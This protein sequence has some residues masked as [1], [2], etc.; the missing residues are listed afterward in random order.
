M[1][2][3]TKLP[4]V[5]DRELRLRARQGLTYWGRCAVAALA[6][7]VTMEEIEATS[8]SVT[9][10]QAGAA[11]F[12][13]VSWLAFLVACVSTLVTADCLSRERRE[14]TLGL[15]LL[16]DLKGLDV[17]LGK[18]CVAG[19]SAAYALVGFLPAV[20]LVVLMGGV[21]LGEIGRTALALLNAAFVALAA[22]MWVSGRSQ[23]RSGAARGSLLL[24]AALCIA[25]GVAALLGLSVYRH[26][27]G[28]AGSLVLVSP[29]APFFLA[30]DANY[31]GA[32]W[33]YWISLA[34]NAVVGW[35]LLVW[36]GL[37]LRFNWKT[38][39][40][41]PPP[42]PIVWE[43]AYEAEA[44][45]LEAQRTELKR[46]D[47]LCWAMS[48][49]RIQN[50]LIWIGALA[51]LLGGTGFS[52]DLLTLGPVSGPR[53]I[54]IASGLH[55]LFSLGA[56]GLLAWAAGRFFFEA[57]RNGELELL[58]STP[59]GAA[60]IVGANWRALCQPLRGAWL[61]VGFLI[62]LGILL[63]PHSV[64]SSAGA[65]WVWG[66]VEKA[67][68][69]AWRVLDIIALCW[70]GMWF[71]LQSRKPISIMAWPAG[72]VVGVPWILSYVLIIWLSF[73]GSA[74]L[75]RGAPGTMFGFWLLVWPVLNLIKDS[76]FIAWAV[77]KLRGE[78]RTRVSLA[79]GNI[80]E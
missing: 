35:G 74:G 31:L 29:S 10:A 78:L 34:V 36:T 22:G 64:A 9:A 69:V 80:M 32:E 71:G 66:L 21:G 48:R 42:K 68:P 6:I 49:M 14:G 57:Q 56:A 39:E 76:V 28:L 7:L 17:V 5:I 1:N 70:I 38:I 24:V 8:G 25:P 65:V 13:A 72:L 2:Y 41:K 40:W 55:L 4:P 23:S 63:G 50:A 16:T 67:L 44:Q 3:L 51:L 47:P 27:T 26:A 18:L 43:P 53:M 37:R 46:K 19:L 77:G 54:G 58:L 12:S 61:L 45:A 59:L 15:L 60:E 62:V 52:W 75:G 73:A 33:Q 30:K 79:A 11:T 20:G